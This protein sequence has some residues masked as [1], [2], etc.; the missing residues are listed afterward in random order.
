MSITVNG[1]MVETAQNGPWRSIHGKDG[2][3]Y[4]HYQCRTK[5]GMTAL[6]EFFEDGADFM[7]FVLFSTSGVH[8]TYNTIEAAE[9][10]LAGDRPSDPEAGDYYQVVTFLIVQPRI[11]CLRY[12]NCRPETADDIAFLKQLREASLR[13]VQK[14]GTESI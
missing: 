9:R 8:G 6:R 5:D 12:G 13:A 1:Q 3:H 14:L 10:W 4:N 2:A 11:C 7:N